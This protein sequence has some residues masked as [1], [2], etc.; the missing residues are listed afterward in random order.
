LSF[1]AEYAEFIEEH[2]KLGAKLISYYGDLEDAREAISDH[3]AGEYDSLSDYAE[4]LTEETTQIPE[5]LRYY[6][7]YEKMG[8][9]LEINDVL[10]IEA[11]SSVHVF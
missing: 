4:Q 10:T 11:G 5:T 1:A 6:I 2:G 3:Y 9:D 8:R 7:D